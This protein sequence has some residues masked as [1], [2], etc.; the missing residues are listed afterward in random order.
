MDA[1][2]VGT[3]YLICLNLD[4]KLETGAAILVSPV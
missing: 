1:K 2:A 4:I 3:I